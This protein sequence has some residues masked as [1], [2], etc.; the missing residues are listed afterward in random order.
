MDIQE[1]DQTVTTEGQDSQSQQTAPEGQTTDQSQ[2][3]TQTS[4]GQTQTETPEDK[5]KKLEE[6]HKKLQSQFTKTS[7]EAEEAKK[8]LEIVKPYW[9][10]EAPSGTAE[11]QAQTLQGEGDLSVSGGEDDGTYISRAEH[12]KEMQK[13]LG[14]VS[15]IIRTNSFVTGFRQ[16]FPDL[17]DK[18]P[19]EQLVTHFFNDRIK[20]GEK[21]ETALQGAISDARTFVKGLQEEGATVAKTEQ[22]KAEQE[23]K[24]KAAAGAAAAAA[25][26]GSSGISAPKTVEPPLTQQDYLK[27]TRAARERTKSVSPI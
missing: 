22:E 20:K 23:R 4:E 6:K 13:V 12:K 3:G 16:Q 11:N 18:G 10:S 14:Q 24:K 2:A 27:K 1:Q 5:Y 26:L 17:G 8:L 21:R 7:Q 15:N 25:G 9:E 19:K